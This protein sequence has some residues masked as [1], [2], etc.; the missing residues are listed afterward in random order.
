MKKTKW[1]KRVKGTPRQ[2]GKP[3]ILDGTS[4]QT[5]KARLPKIKGKAIT[6]YPTGKTVRYSIEDMPIEQL[7]TQTSV[8]IDPNPENFEERV[9]H[10]IKMYNEGETI[11]P[12]LFHRMEDGRIKILDGRARLEAFR[13]LGIP[14]IPAVENGILK[15][16][17]SGATKFFRGVKGFREGVKVAS[18]KGDKLL[19]P[20]KSPA[21]RAGRKAGYTTQKVASSIRKTGARVIEHGKAVYDFLEGKGTVVKG[22]RGGGD[23]VIPSKKFVQTQMKDYVGDRP[24]VI[25]RKVKGKTLK[26][27]GILLDPRTHPLYMQKHGYTDVE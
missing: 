19:E 20:T 22:Q 18:G 2:I 12:I 10:F 14:R 6:R 21:Q 15:A 16:I 4:M 7:D 17:K 25:T 23:L 5:K 26:T 24:C 13:R 1:R 27:Y 11:P 8:I 9:Q 3:F